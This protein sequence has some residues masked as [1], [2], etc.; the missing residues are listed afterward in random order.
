[1]SKNSSLGLTCQKV[2][3]DKYRLT[4][5]TRALHQFNS[6]CNPLYF[7]ELNILVPKIFGKI[8]SKPLKCTTYQT[9]DVP[10]EELSTHNFILENGKTL[11]IKTNKTK[12]SVMQA[13]VVVGQAGYSKLNFHFG[14]LYNYSIKNQEDIKTLFWNQTADLL[15]IFLDYLL[16]SDINVW[17]FINNHNKMD[18]KVI[19]RDTIPEYNFDRSKISFTRQSIDVWNESN[20]IKYN[21]KT[22][23]EVQVHKKRTFK[24][25]F[26]MRNLISYLETK[27]INNETLGI[28]AEHVI[29]DLS[30]IDEPKHFSSRISKKLENDIRDTINSALMKLPKPINHSGSEKGFRGKHSK[31]AY[32]FLLEGNKTLS[33]KTNKN[34]MV[35]PPEVGQPSKETFLIYF[36]HLLESPDCFDKQE[37]KKLCI[38][39]TAEM[40]KIYLLHLFDSDFL[41]WIFQE[42]NVY[43]YKII[44]RLTFDFT[45]NQELFSFTRNLENWNES[46][47][48]KYNGLS[49]GEFQIH[50]KRNSYKFR[51][52]MK[53]LIKLLEV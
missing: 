4:P 23:A 40:M 6:A 52:N 50:S 8:K 18:F 43:Q 17:L 51:F 19:Y 30:Q 38:S 47:T 13:P 12:G 22:I 53:N 15:P 16:I 10:G 7:D 35:C 9:S 41:L 36:S 37:F 39:K 32:D 29:C 24:F 49:I 46:T 21:K 28:T 34:K 44:E 27:K 2:I 42:K 26:N 20:S 45:W 5:S 1:M 48:V 11:S 25:R 14:H 3:C 33:L 31:S